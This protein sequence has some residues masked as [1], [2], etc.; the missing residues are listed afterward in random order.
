MKTA[1]DY[2]TLA[3][4]YDKRAEY[5]SDAIDRMVQEAGVTRDTL[6]ADIGAGTGK[7]TV[8]LLRRG[9]NVVAVEPNDEMRKFGIQNTQG[10]TVKWIEGTGEKTTLRDHSVGLATFGSSFNV[11]DRALTLK[12][13]KRILV[14][15]G[16]FAC[17]W[18]HRDLKDPLQAEVER[19]IHSE[20]A[21]YSYGT[22][23]ED[24][25]EVIKSSGLFQ[26]VRRIEGSV[27]HEIST[28][29]YVEAWKSHATL[30]RQAG[31]KF[32]KVIKAIKK[33]VAGRNTIS[34]PYTT[35]IWYARLVTQ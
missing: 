29:D 27:V 35:R 13:V 11:T 4:Y 22:R 18:N 10:Q 31:E 1:W 14:K 21:E 9:L 34:V 25:T 3:K 16:W 30:A 24:Q 26:A 19:V 8:Q 33:V 5:A 23:R 2:T 15:G 20:V 6:V 12:E 17:M 28:E 7:L 32:S